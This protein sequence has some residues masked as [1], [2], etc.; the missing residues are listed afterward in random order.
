MIRK[1]RSMI[2]LYNPPKPKPLK[3]KPASP[4]KTPLSPEKVSF[5][6]TAF[7]DIVPVVKAQSAKT[8]NMLD[9][10]ELK[11]SDM[12]TETEEAVEADHIVIDTIYAPDVAEDDMD[13]KYQDIGL[14]NDI[15]D[16]GEEQ[17]EEARVV[18]LEPRVS[19]IHL[20]TFL[21]QT[22]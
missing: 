18:K 12:K 6:N 2:D 19:K 7:I 9:M 8:P 21:N 13:D 20:S 10:A 15:D 17:E 3:K 11:Q 14:E 1:L 22:G 4:E 5:N 16:P